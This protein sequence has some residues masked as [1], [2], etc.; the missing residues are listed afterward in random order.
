MGVS[1]IEICLLL[2]KCGIKVT[3]QHNHYSA[4]SVGM[5]SMKSENVTVC[6]V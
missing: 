2:I 1:Y 4:L 3:A 6:N 5:H